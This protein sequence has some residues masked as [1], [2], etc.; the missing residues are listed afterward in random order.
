MQRGV[1]FIH[2]DSLRG[3][4][5][6]RVVLRQVC[7]PPFRFY[8]TNYRQQMTHTHLSSRAGIT[9]HIY[10]IKLIQPL[11]IQIKYISSCVTLAQTYNSACLSIL[12]LSSLHIRKQPVTTSTSI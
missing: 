2:M 3:F 7:L 6:D 12:L 9:D 8:P 1:G 10:H 4:E 5:V 11:A